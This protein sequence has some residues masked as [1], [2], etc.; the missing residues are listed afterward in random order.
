MRFVPLLRYL[1]IVF[2][3][4][5]KCTRKKTVVVQSFLLINEYDGDNGGAGG[6]EKKTISSFFPEPPIM[7]C[8]C[9]HVKLCKLK[10]FRNNPKDTLF[11]FVVDRRR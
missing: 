10:K 11:Y 7:F 6:N 4:Y 1:L 5:P 9:F 3:C 2:S 8:C